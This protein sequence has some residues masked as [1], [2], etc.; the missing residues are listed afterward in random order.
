[1]KEGKVKWFRD[2]GIGFIIEKGSPDKPVLVHYS[3]IA[4]DKKFKTLRAG[5]NVR[6]KTK[7]ILGRDV[8]TYVE[9]I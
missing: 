5:Q 4:Q 8:A 9:P 6:F 3:A 7:K 2:D 1:M